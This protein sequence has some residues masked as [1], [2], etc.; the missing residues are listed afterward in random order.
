LSVVFLSLFAMFQTLN[1]IYLG[2]AASKIEIS[3][4]ETQRVTDGNLLKRFKYFRVSMYA[5]SF[6]T[7]PI[8]ILIPAVFFSLGSF[9][10]FSVGISAIFVTSA[11]GF[12][13]GLLFLLLGKNQATTA[14]ASKTSKSSRT[15]AYPQMDGPSRALMVVRVGA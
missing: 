10:F 12:C 1:M 5:I 14:S 3:L 2:Y 8:P 13:F 6:S 9:P 7:A 15:G 4:K 11:M